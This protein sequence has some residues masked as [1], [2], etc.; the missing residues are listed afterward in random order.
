MIPHEHQL[1]CPTCGEIIDMR[2]LGQVLSHGMMNEE[3]GKYECTPVEATYSTSKK[4]GD[5]VE[6]DK[7]KKP[8]HLN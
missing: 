5:N 7:D 8:L 1:K 2:D 6:W 4:V 3:T